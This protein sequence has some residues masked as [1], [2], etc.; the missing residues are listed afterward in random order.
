MKFSSAVNPDLNFFNMFL[1]HLTSGLALDEI[2]PGVYMEKSAP[3][4]IQFFYS[5]NPLSFI[6]KSQNEIGAPKYL[7]P[8]A[9]APLASP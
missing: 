9:T 4:C 1:Q 7:P 5:E 8:C 3:L 6:N 2:P